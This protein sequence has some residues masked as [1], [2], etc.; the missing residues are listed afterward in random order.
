MNP[1][2]LCCYFFE[3]CP[4][5]IGSIGGLMAVCILR[6]AASAAAIVMAIGFIG[7]GVDNGKGGMNRGFARSTLSSAETVAE[8]VADGN[9]V[10]S[11]EAARDRAV[12]KGNKY[13]VVH[14]FSPP[15]QADMTSP[16]YDLQGDLNGAKGD[17]Q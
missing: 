4:G 12:S 11:A 1:S 16:R 15:V 2:F 5:R 8:G 6:S 17:L 13:T 7:C 9:D 10:P 14:I 3:R